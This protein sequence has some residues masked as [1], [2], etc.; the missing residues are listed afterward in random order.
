MRLIGCGLIFLCG[1]L[2]GLGRKLT[3]DRQVKQWQ[4]ML[5]FLQLAQEELENSAKTSPE[6][7]LTLREPCRDLDFLQN[8]FSAEGSV[9]QRLLLAAEGLND[10]K[11]QALALRFAGRFGTSSTPVQVESLLALQQQTAS[12]LQRLKE[13]NTQQGHLSLTLGLLAGGGAAILLL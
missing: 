13:Q 8:Y 3:L 9:Q 4:Q 11:L 10:K 12:E 1:L 5:L 6:I 2:L 7:L